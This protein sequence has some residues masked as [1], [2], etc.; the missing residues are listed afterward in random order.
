MVTRKKS[1]SEARAEMSRFYA[2]DVVA[3]R[4]GLV[5]HHG[6]VLPGGRVLHNTPLRGEHIG[7]L[8]EFARGKRV[9]RVGGDGRKGALGPMRPYN[10]FTNNC[11][12][13]VSRYTQGRASSRQL[14][15]WVAGM[16]LGAVALALTRHPALGA[17]GYA[18]GRRWAGRA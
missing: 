12:H 13:T 5:M 10:L 18:L 9:Y 15:G 17:A 11:E 4:K 1:A 8:A 7:T 3:R 2:G 6:V 14:R 16:S